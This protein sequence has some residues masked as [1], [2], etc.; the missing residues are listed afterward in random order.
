MDDAPPSEDKRRKTCAECVY[1]VV[2][3]MD[4]TLDQIRHLFLVCV[5]ITANA[6]SNALY[7]TNVIL[8]HEIFI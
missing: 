6:I 2:V 7:L 1:V 8:L 3:G 5:T 4:L